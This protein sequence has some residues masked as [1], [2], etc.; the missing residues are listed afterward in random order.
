[1]KQ[2]Y[3]LFVILAVLVMPF[4]AFA[5]DRNND[6]EVI[7][8]DPRTSRF[9]AVEGEVLVKFRDNAA[10]R[11]T[12]TRSGEYQT[13]GI[14]AVDDV[15]SSF[16][17]EKV[18]QLCPANPTRSLRRSPSYGG[19]EVVEHDMTKL[20]RIRL[21][22]DDRQ[23]S[24]ELIEQL[25]QCGDIEYTE[26]NYIVSALETVSSHPEFVEGS[27][28]RREVEGKGNNYPL[29]I[30]NCQLSVDGGTR[31]GAYFNA[32]AYTSEP[33]YSTQWGI[34]AVR[35]PELWAA[36]TSSNTARKVIAIIDTGVDT[37]HPDLADNIWTNP[38][39]SQTANGYDNDNNGY[40][41]DLH[42]WDF[43]NQTGIMHDFN[44]HGTHC[45][46]IAA[47]VGTNGIG[48]TGANPQALIM[49]LSALQS[50]GT[51]DIA[52]IIRAINYAA[53]NGADVLSMSFGSYAYSIALEQAL[54][55]A[56]QSAVL[57]AA[58]GNDGYHIDPRCCLDPAHAIWDGPMFPAAFTFVL[59]VQATQQSGGL[60]GFS[61]IDCD[62]PT[63]SQ[64]GEE[65]LY[66]YELRA[67]GASI[68]STVPNG[69]YRNYNGTSMACPLV[70]GGVSA[71]LHAKPYPTQ[72]MLWGDLI[73]YSGDNVDFK[74]VYDAGP[75]PA[76]LQFVA[77][78]VC[79][80]S[81][82]DG[83]NRPDAGE[84]MDIYPTIRT[85]WGAT[86]DI[87]LWIDFAEFEDTTT[88][89]FLQNNVDFG[90]SLSAYAKG[91]SVNPI[92][93][94]I[95][96]NVVDGRYVKLVLHASSPDAEED[97]TFPFTI[98]VENGVELGG[99][100]TDTLVLHA[101]VHYIVTHNLA[102][103]ETGLLIIEP[104]TTL[105]FAD[106]VSISN[107]GKIYAVG[108][109]DSLIT[110]TKRDLG[111]A[112][113]GIR[114]N[115]TDTLKYCIFEYGIGSPNSDQAFL[116][117]QISSS[118]SL[119]NGYR[120]YQAPYIE[121]SIIRNNRSGNLT[122]NLIFINS[123]MC[124]NNNYSV[125]IMDILGFVQGYTATAVLFL[126]GLHQNVNYVNN[127]S[128]G[129]A[130]RFQNGGMQ[131]DN[132]FL[133]ELYANIY[134]NKFSYNNKE[135]EY[136]FDSNTA[137][138]ISLN[139]NIYL[140]SVREDIVRRRLYDFEYPGST[141]FGRINIDNMATRPVAEAHGIVWKVEVN[142]HDAQDE[143][144][145]IP[146]LGIGSHEFKVYFNR[147]MDVSVDPMIAMGVRPP[148]TQNP[149]TQKGQ[150]SADSTIYTVMLSLTNKFTDGLNR[151]YV[152][153]ARDNEHFEIPVENTRFNVYVSA[154]GSL[155][156]EFVATPGLG[157][158]D[159][160]WNNNE[161]DYNDFLGYNM[162]RYIYDSLLVNRHY[163]SNCS[164]YVYDTVFAPTDTVMLNTSLIQDTL[165]T[166][167]DVTPGQRY[168][169]FYKVMRT[170]LTESVSPSKV[171]STI[172][173][174]SVRGDAN[175]SMAVD[176]A[177]VVTTVNYI[178]NQN[179][180]PFIFEA[181]DVNADGNIN[182]LDI[183]GIINII[184]HPGR[185]TASEVAT[186]RYSIEDG[187]LYVETPVELG[188]VQF[189][190]NMPHDNAIEVLAALNGFE[191]VNS[192][193]GDDQYMFMAYSMSG[194]KLSAGRHAL[195]RIGD[196]GIDEIILSDPYGNNVNAVFNVT[197]VDFVENMRIGEPYPNPFN[198][199]VVIPFTVKFS[200]SE[201][202]EFVMTD[203]IGCVIDTKNVGRYGNGSHE[204]TWTPS[205]ELKPGI[206]FIETK[207]NG[208]VVNKAKVVCVK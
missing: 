87:T 124:D 135:V 169:Y 114:L 62:G 161:V 101:D 77:Y 79:D 132:P 76:V 72:E 33:M 194:R 188:G 97:L 17:M 4:I 9:D 88:I 61:N 127:N 171:V 205:S 10:V 63:F 51:G 32:A 165:F 176:V 96:D 112:W 11:M 157:K 179:P 24:Y 27:V 43:V 83:D 50:N 186:A 202:I 152:A 19:G 126:P 29:S 170:D 136:Y 172:P 66:N 109:Q 141:T 204:Y 113:K 107:S 40:V 133:T 46:G 185:A 193:V 5:Q 16:G 192:W 47:A 181:A 178:T 30:A 146:P 94:R 54:A 140:G 20:Y 41:D 159:L 162:Y 25:K 53:R 207:S 138:E 91:K 1:M 39:E 144:D 164:C 74:A 203:A 26:P 163:D 59:G 55:Q 14:R 125:E 108:T 123:N 65:Q 175:G 75:A 86:Q 38:N 93:M 110:F 44:S 131:A 121:N 151:I 155:S 35:L 23:R 130:I 168:Y 129:V 105:K 57:V 122:R 70:A 158:V 183:V 139:G 2:P 156:S 90:R 173:L 13:C 3:R 82:G 95:A 154:A 208:I 67:P 31:S 147:A 106:N 200:E 56:Y 115:Y 166:D 69:G 198:S 100:I 143:L 103:T 104:G 206:Y 99:M 148:Y 187:I 7:K 120:V 6:D 182:V 199:S 8:L 73:N 84:T 78:E 28:S 150:W 45:A 111:V 89:E 52:T 160:E 196:A 116:Y 128:S 167:Y 117:G 34:P 71:L 184:L 48:M 142:G 189:T 145:S 201:E 137:R 21:N 195:L 80:S 197:S 119:I 191:R 58:A 18:E 180:Q 36:D 64:F 98:N 177:D 174:S 49:P 190:F 15:L 153:N 42:G 134:G 85:V 68:Y 149:I 60:T 102:I 37:D 22:A 92:R 118:A 81:L 12:T